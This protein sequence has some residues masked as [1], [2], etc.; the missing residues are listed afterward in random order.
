MLGF[1]G[2]SDVHMTMTWDGAQAE[3]DA[4]KTFS[5]LR[6]GLKET[7][8]DSA[9]FQSVMTGAFTKIFD[10]GTKVVGMI[11]TGMAAGARTLIGS[12]IN[13]GKAGVQTVGQFEK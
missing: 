12:V 11:G 13:L 6:E 4:R 3:R 5:H 9:L 10:L 8:K 1:L 2:D 7:K